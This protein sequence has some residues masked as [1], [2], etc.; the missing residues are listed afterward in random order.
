VWTRT[1]NHSARV[2]PAVAVAVGEAGDEVADRVRVVE[3]GPLVLDPA[4]GL[5]SRLFFER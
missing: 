2:P 1:S 5:V 4:V 3:V